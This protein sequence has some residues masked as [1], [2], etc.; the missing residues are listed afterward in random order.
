MDIIQQ[1]V[2]HFRVLRKLTIGQFWSCEHNDVCDAD[3][4][5]SY[6]NKVIILFFCT[7]KLFSSLYNIK[8]ETL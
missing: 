5:A 4:E 7:Q 1:T 3:P 8:V 6:L 2:Q